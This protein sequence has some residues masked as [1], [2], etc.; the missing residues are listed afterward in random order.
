MWLKRYKSLLL[1]LAIILGILLYK[2]L[3]IFIN[4]VPFLIFFIL[5]FAYSSLH[6]RRL[7]FTKIN[8]LLLIIHLISSVLIYAVCYFAFNSVVSQG[9]LVG[10]ICPVASASS[11][12]V[13]ALGGDKEKSIVHTLCDNVMVAFAAPIMLSFSE[14][15]K[16]ISFIQS[17]LILMAKVIPITVLP[18]GLLI[19]MRRFFPRTAYKL[20]RFDWV[21]ILLWSIALMINFS[22]TTF[23]VFNLGKDYSAD[24]IIMIAASLLL[25]ILFF[26]AGK[27]LGKPLNQSILCGQALGQKNTGLGIW[28]AYTYFSNPLTTIFCAAYSLWQNMFNSL[29]MYLHDKKE[30]KTT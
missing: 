21:S 22:K 29:Q 15:D 5:F 27:K 17:V 1:P 12:V 6:F 4:A 14:L 28:M 30:S 3:H 25:C 2:K 24:I 19:I 26:V 20:S 23:A 16:N 8:A 7:R 18:L 11:A 9:I 13:G 10:L